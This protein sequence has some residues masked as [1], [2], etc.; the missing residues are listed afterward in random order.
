MAPAGSAFF[1]PDWCSRWPRAPPLPRR[2]AA[3]RRSE[4]WSNERSTPPRG[5]TITRARRPSQGRSRHGRAAA[6]RGRRPRPAVV[7]FLYRRGSHEDGD[8]PTPDALSADQGEDLR[9][10]RKGDRELYVDGLPPQRRAEGSGFRRRQFRLR[11][12]ARRGG[13]ER[14]S[15]RRRSAHRRAAESFSHASGATASIAPNFASSGAR[16]CDPWPTTTIATRS[17]GG[18]SS[19]AT[20]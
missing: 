7:L 14:L 4:T 17:G 11:L 12:L 5:S 10:E 20:R 6:R 1:S 16:T 13:S 15:V 19:R 8:L 2:R 9:R 18:M 3:P